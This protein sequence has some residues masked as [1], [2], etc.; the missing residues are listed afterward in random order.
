MRSGCRF[1]VIIFLVAVAIGDSLQAQEHLQAK[2]YNFLREHVQSSKV[3]KSFEG[4]MATPLD[5]LAVDYECMQLVSRA[6]GMEFRFRQNYKGISVHKSEAIVNL[7]WDGSLSSISSNFQADLEMEMQPQSLTPKLTEDEAV[8]VIRQLAWEGDGAGPDAEV[9]LQLVILSHQNPGLSRRRR[10]SPM[11]IQGDGHEQEQEEEERDRLAYNVC[12]IEEGLVAMHGLVDAHTGELLHS[13]TDMDMDTEGKECLHL[14]NDKDDGAERASAFKWMSQ[15][16]VA[17]AATPKRITPRRTP[18]RRTATR[19]HRPRNTRTPSRRRT[20]RRTMR[21]TPPRPHVSIGSGSNLLSP[22]SIKY[23]IG[24]GEYVYLPNAAEK[25]YPDFAAVGIKLPSGDLRVYSG[26]GKT[27]LIV[28]GRKLKSVLRTKQRINVKWAPP[29]YYT[30]DLEA[31]YHEPDTGSTHG[32]VHIETWTGDMGASW[33]HGEIT[34]THSSDGGINWS[35]ATFTKKDYV[36]SSAGPYRYRGISTG[37]GAHWA[38]GS[39]NFLFIYYV[40]MWAEWKDGG[41]RPGRC[42][43]RSSKAC[44]FRPGCWNKLYRGAFQ[45]PGTV[46]G[47]PQTQQGYCSNVDDIYGTSTSVILLKNTRQRIYVNLPTSFVGWLGVSLDGASWQRANGN[48]IPYLKPLYAGESA[49]SRVGFQGY[50]SLVEDEAGNYFMYAFVVGL[51]GNPNRAIVSYPISFERSTIGGCAGRVGLARYRNANGAVRV[52]GQPV[53]PRVWRRVGD[54]GYVSVCYGRPLQR[55]VYCISS[56][57]KQQFL[58]LESECKSRAKAPDGSAVYFGGGAGQTRMSFKPGLVPLYRCYYPNQRKYDYTVSRPCGAGAKLLGFIMP[59]GSDWSTGGLASLDAD[60]FYDPSYNYTYPEGEWD[61]DAALNAESREEMYKEA[62]SEGLLNPASS[63]SSLSP[64]LL[65]GVSVGVVVV[66]VGVLAVALVAYVRRRRKRLT[67]Y[68]APGTPH[69]LSPKTPA[70][71]PKGLRKTLSKALISVSSASQA[72]AQAHA[73]GAQEASA[74]GYDATPPRT[75]TS[76][77]S[78]TSRS[79]ELKG[80]P[81]LRVA[82]FEGQPPE[83]PTSSNPSTSTP[84][85]T[86]ATTP[87]NMVEDNTK[88]K[89]KHIL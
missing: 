58:A 28:K 39:G 80:L 5:D 81:P 34:Y 87:V 84:T 49:I 48:F 51:D 17:A 73:Q 71:T 13:N 46:L 4:S 76:P 11:D 66:V 25:H 19:T 2:A 60:P 43:A 21:P 63:S 3:P 9:H 77:A 12:L 56:S 16:L 68:A 75:P 70:H 40:D 69:P 14:L 31:V 26:K 35:P 18:R 6:D 33:F 44:R 64:G 30:N 42:I 53:D 15:P 79:K 38:V 1:L 50:H 22:E 36:V 89:P 29:A 37:T 41:H 78:G 20:P 8:Q 7:R 59:P 82:W 32:F 23:T 61:F 85:S 83:G 57:I 65:A 24:A 67:E 55:M 10:V 45:Q 62:E 47:A 86:L 54:V 72:Q 52:T 88:S 74:K 27:D